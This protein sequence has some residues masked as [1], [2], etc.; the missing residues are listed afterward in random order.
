MSNILIDLWGRQ[1]CFCPPYAKTD[2]M[3]YPVPTP[4]AIRGILDAIYCK[5]SEFF[6]QVKKIEIMK[7]VL[8]ETCR[9]NELNK[10]MAGGRKKIDPIDIANSD[11]RAM[12]TTS[13]LFDVKYRVTAVIVPRNEH[14]HNLA[15]LEAQAIRRI[16]KGQC[17]RQPYFGI[18]E[19]TCHFGSADLSAAPVSLDAAYGLMP[20]D[21]FTPWDGPDGTFSLSLFDCVVKNG[22]IDVPDYDSDLVL[23][24]TGGGSVC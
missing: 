17:F 22:V 12:R 5:P 1:A 16:S 21:T 3:S 20:Y 6:W 9:R 24:V 4:S 7:P 8:Y 10:A 14:E 15:G 19:F 13:F 23:K 11:N 2:R 18:R